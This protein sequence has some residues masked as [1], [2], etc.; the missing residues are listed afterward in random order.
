MRMKTV[1]SAG[2]QRLHAAVKA[3][4]GASAPYFITE[5]QMG[6]RDSLVTGAGAPRAHE[7]SPPTPRPGSHATS[8]ETRPSSSASE[9]SN[10]AKDHLGRLISKR[11]A[12]K[13]VNQDRRDICKLLSRERPL[14]YD[15][16]ERG[17]CSNRLFYINIPDYNRNT[18]L[19][20]DENSLNSQ[21][22]SSRS[23]SIQL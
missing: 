23:F 19:L 14:H 3:P 8:C 22:E 7:D 2:G 18:L 15:Y 1:D 17:V 9:S 6:M 11:S 21:D 20:P 4:H 5:I 12:P 16:L 10:R 13:R